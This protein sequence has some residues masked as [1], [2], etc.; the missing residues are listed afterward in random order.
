MTEHGTLAQRQAA[1][2]RALVAEGP[3]PTGFDAAAVVAAGAV[4]RH[5]RD[6]HARAGVQRRRWLRR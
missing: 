2:V 3:V 5:K 6:A 4:C 1:L